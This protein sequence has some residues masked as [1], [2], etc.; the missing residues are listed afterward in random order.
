MG[1]EWWWSAAKKKIEEEGHA[2]SLLLSTAVFH[3]LLHEFSVALPAS[4][5]VSVVIFLQAMNG[6]G[7]KLVEQSQRGLNESTCR[8]QSSDARAWHGLSSYGLAGLAID[9]VVF[10]DHGKASERKA[11]IPG[12]TDAP[13]RLQLPYHSIQSN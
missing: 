2:G 3:L 11:G 4:Q 10:P 12:A 9:A 7:K 13:S 6:L 8:G 1:G 5:G